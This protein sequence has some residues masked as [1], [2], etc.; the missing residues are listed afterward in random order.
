MKLTRFY[1]LFVLCVLR[2]NSQAQQADTLCLLDT[3]DVAVSPYC[4]VWM[5]DKA[6]FPDTYFYDTTGKV[7]RTADLF[8]DKPVIFITGSYSCPAFRNNATRIR[9]EMRKKAET[10]DIYFVYLHEAHPVKGSPYGPI[11][12]NYFLNVQENVY[13]ERQTY[14]YERMDYA[15]RLKHDYN[16]IS[17]ILIDN[18]HNDFFLQV[19]SGPNG[20]MEFTADRVLK[21]QRAWYYN[22]IQKRKTKRRLRQQARKK[23]KEQIKWIRKI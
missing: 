10:H 2:A 15:R 19:F 14:L 13:I 17:P 8:K 23:Y 20:Y 21:H 5:E 16:I 12:D 22:K 11:M 9:R 18:E 3:N 7:I 1:I 6:K 4:F